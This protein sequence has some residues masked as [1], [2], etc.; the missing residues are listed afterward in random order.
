MRSHCNGVPLS[1]E[2]DEKSFKLLFYVIARNGGI[3]PVEVKAGK[4]GILKSLHQYLL[5]K[6]GKIAFRFDMN[7]PGRQELEPSI[8]IGG[9]QNETD[10][11]AFSLISLPLYAVEELNRICDHINKETR[12]G[13]EGFGG[14]NRFQCHL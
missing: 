11:V 7:Q 13:R 14:R 10:K 4:S 12:P 9:T 6:G 5:Q 1:A 8:R 3:Y 2:S